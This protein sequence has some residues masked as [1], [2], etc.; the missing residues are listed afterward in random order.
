MTTHQDRNDE[1]SVSAN[2]SQNTAS[3]LKKVEAC[4]ELK[5]A[6]SGDIGDVVAKHEELILHYYRDVQDQAQH[7]FRSAQRVATIGFGVLIVTLVYT[8][9]FDALSRFHMGSLSQSS[10]ETIT[11][12]SI[13][14]FSGVL[15]EFVSAIQFWLYARASRQFGA[16]HICLERTH[17]YL[18]AFKIAE[19]ITE[20]KRDETLEK[21]VC[22]MANAPMITLR[23]IN[24]VG[25]ESSEVNRSTYSAALANNQF[26]R[27]IT[28]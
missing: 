13:G 11:T 15:I 3:H 10:A 5:T 17:R 16:F 24:S 21:L 18:V 23:D 25:L 8:L 6:L 7:S 28:S 27:V 2:G 20:E 19:K 9:M 4:K 22:I 14:V 26:D 1:E 12:A